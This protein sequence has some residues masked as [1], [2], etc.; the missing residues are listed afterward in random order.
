MTPP[1]EA[2]LDRPGY[3]V[4]NARKPAIQSAPP[5]MLALDDGERR[6]RRRPDVGPDFHV[7]YDQTTPPSIASQCERPTV[8]LTELRGSYLEKPET[9]GLTVIFLCLTPEARILAQTME[10]GQ[11]N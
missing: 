9:Y 3:V 2:G 8:T 11:I 1:H 6:G 4:V 10:Q 7:S 5:R